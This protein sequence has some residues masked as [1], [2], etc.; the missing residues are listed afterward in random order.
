VRL[1]RNVVEL[2]YLK[3]VMA[4]DLVALSTQLTRYIIG[5]ALFF[6]TIGGVCNALVFSRKNLRQFPCSLYY[7][8]HSIICLLLLY[9]TVLLRYLADVYLIDLISQSPNTCKMFLYSSTALR[10][11]SA[12]FI[13][14]SSIDRFLASS[15]SQKLRPLSQIKYAIYNI[16]LTIMTIAILFIYIPIYFGNSSPSGLTCNSNG[17]GALTLAHNILNSFILAFFVPL[18]LILFNILTFKN[19][20]RRRQL[21]HTTNTAAQQNQNR[22]MIR[23]MVSQSLSYLILVAPGALFSVYTVF[24][25]P[26]TSAQLLFT[27]KLFFLF[28]YVHPSIIFYVNTLASRTY[29]VEAIKILNNVVKFVFHSTIIERHMIQGEQRQQRQVKNTIQNSRPIQVIETNV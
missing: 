13:L 20:Q 8:A 24:V 12:L 11:L 10:S 28:Q 26:Q 5:C 16:I 1:N 3:L 22:H 4:V 27:Y 18:M 29:R 2:Q 25:P 19:I 17:H 21:V 15:S 7:L 9:T 23:L 6:G 14:W